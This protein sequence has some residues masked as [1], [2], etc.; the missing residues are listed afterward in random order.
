MLYAKEIKVEKI[1]TVNFVDVLNCLRHQECEELGIDMHESGVNYKLPDGRDNI[2]DRLW[3]KISNKRFG[4]QGFTNDA[5]FQYYFP[6]F[7]GEPFM[8]E[9]EEKLYEA[10]K[11]GLNGYGNVVFWV[12]W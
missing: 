7:N 3:N 5:F 4:N 8:D 10:V 11:H 12:S 9:D 6:I 1:K 2:K